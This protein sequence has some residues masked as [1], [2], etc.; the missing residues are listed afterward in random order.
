MTE[1][2]F[3]KFWLFDPKNH[4]IQGKIHI[5]YSWNTQANIS[6]WGSFSM[7]DAELITRLNTLSPELYTSCDEAVSKAV[8]KM[9]MK[10]RIIVDAHVHYE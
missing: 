1:K 7:M 10:E 2:T 6:V 4:I 5:F 9:F 8:A 3:N